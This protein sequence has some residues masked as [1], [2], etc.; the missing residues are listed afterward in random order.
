MGYLLQVFPFATIYYS[1]DK[2]NPGISLKLAD[3][4]LKEND[5]D[6]DEDKFYFEKINDPNLNGMKAQPQKLNLL[7][8]SSMLNLPKIYLQNG[9]NNLFKAIG[10][11][12]NLNPT[13]SIDL[14]ILG[15]LQSD[16]NIVYHIP[17]REK[18]ESI[19]RNKVS[20][21]GMMLKSV[22]NRLNISSMNMNMNST[23]N[24]RYATL[25]NK[26]SLN[27]TKMENSQ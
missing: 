22:D 7:L 9:L 27:N 2:L 15:F 6:W 14:G 11:K 12:L 3:I 20:I 23:D 16:D 19:F 4:F 8:I 13:C 1:K 18:K 25:L 26:S 5:L 10:E 24:N 17:I 21:R